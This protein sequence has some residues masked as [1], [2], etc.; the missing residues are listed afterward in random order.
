MTR[1][2]SRMARE[3]SV[4]LRETSFV[5]RRGFR[6]P[7]DPSFVMQKCSRAWREHYFAMQ[8]E[9]A[10]SGIRS[11]V[12]GGDSAASE[13]LLD[14]HCITTATLEAIPHPGLHPG[15]SVG[16]PAGLALAPELHS[17]VNRR[18]EQR[19]PYVA[20]LGEGRPPAAT[21]RP[22]RVPSASC[23]PPLQKP[24]VSR[25]D[26]E[27]LPRRPAGGSSRPTGGVGRALAVDPSPAS[28]DDHPPCP[29]WPT[30][31]WW[32]SSR[33]VTRRDRAGSD[34]CFRGAAR[35]PGARRRQVQV[36]LRPR[37]QFLE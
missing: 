23:G 21:G 12:G 36:L 37:I 24:V 10:A 32:I 6:V 3:R 11:P 31:S 1:L 17:E 2:S 8:N 9:G 27:I 14:A 7:R 28:C 26:S 18:V 5:L 15:L 30:R 34:D 13:G 29:P 16:R 20:T 19:W 35:D 25:C 22:R 33:T 4:V